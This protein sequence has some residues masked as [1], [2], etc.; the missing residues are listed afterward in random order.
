[1]DPRWNTAVR[2]HGRR[3][4]LVPRLTRLCFSTSTG[5][6]KMTSRPETQIGLVYN[7]S[8]LSYRNISNMFVSKTV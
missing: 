4:E 1:M 6:L 2:S 7:M 8:A 3:M 5:I